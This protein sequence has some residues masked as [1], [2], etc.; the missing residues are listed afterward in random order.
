M[1]DNTRLASKIRLQTQ[2]LDQNNTDH[3]EILSALLKVLEDGG[4]SHA[5]RTLSAR[6]MI[7][8][9]LDTHHPHLDISKAMDRWKKD[10]KEENEKQL[11]ESAKR[12]IPYYS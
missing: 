5:W 1:C 2:L 8:A 4:K 9:S 3:S 10:H 7:L 12:I 6:R 11:G